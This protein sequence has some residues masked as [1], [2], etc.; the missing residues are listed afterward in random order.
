MKRVYGEC[1]LRKVSRSR[2]SKTACLAIFGGRRCCS[3]CLQS[4]R[5]KRLKDEG[6]NNDE[7]TSGEKSFTQQVVVVGVIDREIS[8][9]SF[10]TTENVEYMGKTLVPPSSDHSVNPVYSVVVQPRTIGPCLPINFGNDS[11]SGFRGK[12]RFVLHETDK[13]ATPFSCR[14]SVAMMRWV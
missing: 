13:I 9:L 10:S 4:C 8:K 1:R 5:G 12:S 6:E 14:L 7:G 2:C 11:L 3:F